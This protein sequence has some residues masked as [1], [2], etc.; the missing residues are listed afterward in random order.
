MVFSEKA[1]WKKIADAEA[2][3]RFKESMDEKNICTN[4][5]AALK[6]IENGTYTKCAAC[7]ESISVK[8]M[9]EDVLDTITCSDGCEKELFKVLLLG[10]SAKLI[11]FANKN[12]RKVTSEMGEQNSHVSV[13]NH[14]G[15]VIINT[16][17]GIPLSE[18]ARKAGFKAERLLSRLE[19]GEYRFC[20]DC[21][22]KIPSARQL[23]EPISDRCCTC[24][25]A[26]ALKD[27]VSGYDGPRRLSRLVALPLS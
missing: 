7:G 20:S 15:D 25:N 6:R 23:A 11:S 13:S 22:E 26:N 24:K 8:R 27:S 16:H 1:H 19:K 18:R 4:L 17:E 10:S 5:V 14:E 2:V 21:G 12:I 3:R 9:M